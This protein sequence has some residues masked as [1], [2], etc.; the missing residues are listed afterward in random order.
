VQAQPVGRRNENAS[1]FAAYAVCCYAGHGY[2]SSEL[3]GQWSKVAA[4]SPLCS[5]GC[6]AE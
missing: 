3:F 1:T 6:E 4:L 5:N 2:Q